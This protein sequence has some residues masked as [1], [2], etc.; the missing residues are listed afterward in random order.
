MHKDESDVGN[1][2]AKGNEGS[3]LRRDERVGYH[4]GKLFSFLSAENPVKNF[5]VYFWPSLKAF[6]AMSEGTGKPLFDHR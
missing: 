4:K 6:D 1:E 2:G 3:R 5:A